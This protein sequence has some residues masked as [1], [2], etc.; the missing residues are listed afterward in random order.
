MI[1]TVGWHYTKQVFGCMM[2]YCAST[3]KVFP[4]QRTITKYALLSIWWL[5]FA[6]GNR[7]ARRTTS[8]S[9]KYSSICLTSSFRSPL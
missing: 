2:V 7:P 8:R 9:S 5:N 6:Q 4:R 3:G 1:F